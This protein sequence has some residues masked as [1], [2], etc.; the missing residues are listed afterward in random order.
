MSN[1]STFDE[2]YIMRT[3]AALPQESP[4]DKTATYK[5]DLDYAKPVTEGKSAF[6]FNLEHYAPGRAHERSTG[7]LDGQEGH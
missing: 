6:C 5:G 4:L 7:R 2:L 1:E 3:I